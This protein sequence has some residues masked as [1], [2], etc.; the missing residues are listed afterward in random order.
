MGVVG[1][2]GGGGV[3]EE[4]TKPLTHSY[5]L[6]QPLVAITACCSTPI[7]GPLKFVENILKRQE[8]RLR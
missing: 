3:Q 1:V 8:Q 7:L 6:T 4:T 2:R 5:V